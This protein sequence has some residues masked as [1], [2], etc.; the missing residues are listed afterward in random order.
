MINS[1]MKD[2]SK[3]FSFVAEID[4]P[5]E[6]FLDA[7][8]KII[9]RTSQNNFIISRN[10]DKFELSYWDLITRYKIN[11]SETSNQLYLLFRTEKEEK[12]EKIKLKQFITIM[13]EDFFK[14]VL[15][16]LILAKH[17]GI[18]SSNIDVWFRDSDFNVDIFKENKINYQRH[19]LLVGV[20]LQNWTELLMVFCP[21]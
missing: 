7:E 3:L 14:G 13:K 20:E 2:S 19:E 5:R 12:R 1:A 6:I 15:D 10:G 18:P 9:N 8:P 17:L 16:T 4:V 21:E 11:R